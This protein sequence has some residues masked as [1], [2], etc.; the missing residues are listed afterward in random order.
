[1][2]FGETSSLLGVEGIA[3]LQPEVSPKTA[4]S[5]FIPEGKARNL[6]SHDSRLPSRGRQLSNTARRSR[7]GTAHMHPSPEVYS[8]AARMPRTA[9]RCYTAGSTPLPEMNRMLAPS[10]GWE[11][12]NALEE[13][14]IRGCTSRNR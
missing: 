7:E 9:I 2:V 1:M 10:V 4:T 14:V 13:L 6:L 11:S 3:G 5:G 8:A 12:S